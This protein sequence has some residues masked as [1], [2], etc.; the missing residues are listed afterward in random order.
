MGIDGGQVVVQG[1]GELFHDYIG[2][3]G[4]HAI[5][6]GTEDYIQPHVWLSFRLL[7]MRSAGWKDVT[8]DELG[9]VS[10]ASALFG[11]QPGSW[12][13][14]YAHLA[15][16]PDERVANATGFG[17]EWVRF[18]DI[19]AAWAFVVESVDKDR[20]AMG[21]HWENVL[22]GGYR[23]AERSRDRM[24]FAM[25]DGPDTYAKWWT[26]EE[27]GEWVTLV[28]GWNTR[29]LG[30]HTVRVPAKPAD[31]TAREVIGNLIGWSTEP[32]AK[33]RQNHREATFGLAG[34]EAY[35]RDCADLAGHQ[36][37]T[38][39]HDVNGQWALRNSSSVYLSGVAEAG[40][41]PAE[42]NRHLLAAADAYRMAYA[43]WQELY[44]QLGHN[45]PGRAGKMPG[46]RE[47]GAAAVR[48]A[49]DSERVAIE[50]LKTAAGTIG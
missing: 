37:W 36:D 48:R 27:F 8:F 24:V 41:F 32:P 21:W 15:V 31:E 26:W 13:P 28:D 46:R 7:Q 6:V 10:G 30:R 45:A 14:K 11:Y 43:N 35:A 22:F 9:A 18:A 12:M 34:I 38:A 33:V 2:R 47:A 5:S 4:Q 42:A 17:H 1:I 50:E 3:Y 16:A 40:L 23:G 49:L 39:C 19:E 20:P 44:E 29:S 25:A